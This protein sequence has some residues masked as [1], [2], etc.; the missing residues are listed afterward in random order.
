ME[1]HD[2]VLRRDFSSGNLYTRISRPTIFKRDEST[3]SSIDRAFLLDFI[4]LPI[5]TTERKWKRERNS[6][7][8]GI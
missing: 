7:E 5:A 8:T 3:V 2:G 6:M 4:F 1:N